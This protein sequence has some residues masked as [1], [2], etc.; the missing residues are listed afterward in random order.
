M[1]LG[2]YSGKGRYSV[3]VC[4]ETKRKI[5]NAMEAIQSFSMPKTEIDESQPWL[6]FSLIFIEIISVFKL[7]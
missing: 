3:C 2:N 4:M 6:W 5:C 7:N 1:M